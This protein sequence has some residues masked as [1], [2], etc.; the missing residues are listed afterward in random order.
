MQQLSANCRVRL[1]GIGLPDWY[2]LA[3]VAKEELGR[4][5]TESIDKVNNPPDNI[6]STFALIQEARKPGVSFYEA[7]KNPLTWQFLQLY[8]FV[9]CDLSILT[10]TKLEMLKLSDD[11]CILTGNMKELIDFIVVFSQQ[12]TSQYLA[13]CFFLI[14][15]HEGFSKALT[16][17]SKVATEN[18]L[19]TVNHRD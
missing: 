9:R 11:C 1:I 19:F 10:E 16:R 2:S 13:D 5:I 8:F 4:S 3:T 18:G 6:L 14:L 12:L 15:E 7:V 17:L